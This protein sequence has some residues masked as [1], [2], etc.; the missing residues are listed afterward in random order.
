MLVPF[1]YGLEKCALK[2]SIEHLMA[3]GQI[4]YHGYALQKKMQVFFPENYICHF[5]FF[6]YDYCNSQLL[7]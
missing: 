1:F 5:H 3:I 6:L 7:L 4:F 2:F